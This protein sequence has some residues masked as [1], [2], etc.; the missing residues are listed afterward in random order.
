MKAIIPSVGNI[1]LGAIYRPPHKSISSFNDQL[2]IILPNLATSRTV[3]AGDMNIDVLKADKC[4]LTSD[5]LNMM[6]SF[7]FANGI[8]IPTYES[9][10]TNTESSCL[11]HIWSNMAHDTSNFVISS[12]I[13]D[14]FAVCAVFKLNVDSDQKTK[15][16]F[17]DFCSSK[18]EKFS[19]SYLAELNSFCP[20]RHDVNLYAKYLER[21]LLDLLTNIFP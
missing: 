12:G 19:A 15:I 7:G 14:H 1:N 4:K 5:Y 21:F 2:E 16:I 17:R 3:I 6:S 13:A 9:P 20:P 8:N 11:D 10:A 18:L